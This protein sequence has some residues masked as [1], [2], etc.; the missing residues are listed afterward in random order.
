MRPNTKHDKQ[1]Q[2]ASA[3]AKY[4][5]LEEG[6]AV[7][8][9]PEDARSA[10][11]SSY[12]Q[13]PIVDELPRVSGTDRQQSQAYR[14]ERRA[15]GPESEITALPRLQVY[16][17]GNFEVYCRGERISVGRNSK[18]LA[19]LKYLLAHRI[20]PVSRDY[21]M[22]WLWPNSDLKK[23]RWSLNSAVYTLRRWCGKGF[24]RQGSTDYI[25]LRAGYYR[26]SP[27]LQVSS[28]VEEF[29]DRY[30]TGR[31]LEKTRR[32][33]DAAEEYEKAVELYRGDYLVDDLYEDWTMI[34]R[35]RLLN[36]YLDILD[37][38]S[39][40]Y[41]ETGQ[42]RKS[43]A[44]CYKLLE[45]DCCHENSYHLLMR[46]YARLGLRT[47]AL[48]QYRLCEAMLKRQYGMTPSPEAQ[49]LYRSVVKG[50]IV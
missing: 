22:D 12:R 1:N 45:K 47:Q 41:M 30:R 9:V 15:G 38:L 26:L 17:F 11:R 36:A 44:R 19:I 6:A 31:L 20:Q 24:P 33:Q 4:L 28:D 5:S 13:G 18:A 39:K 10:T 21:L 25:L 50:V 27:E 43:I 14:S 37:R 3:E 42:L 46:C 7:T 35:E 23:A 16:F 8:G 29:D 2:S 49:A 34:E 32:V 48:N 40:Y